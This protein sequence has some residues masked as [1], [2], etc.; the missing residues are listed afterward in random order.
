MTFRPPIVHTIPVLRSAT[1]N[2]V[3]NNSAL[4][5]PNP[6]VPFSQ[7]DWPVC[8]RAGVP[9]PDTVRVTGL[10]LLAPN[11]KVPFVNGNWPLP[12]RGAYVLRVTDTTNL[13]LTLLAPIIAP[14]PFFNTN[15]PLPARRSSSVTFEPISPLKTLLAPA[16]PFSSTDWPAPTRV[17]LSLHQE[18]TSSV[19]PLRAPNPSMPFR[20]NDWPT[21]Q[22][23]SSQ[24]L[25]EVW[26]NQLTRMLTSG[27]PFSQFDWP[28]PKR[29]VYPGLQNFDAVLNLNLHPGAV[30]RAF[31]VNLI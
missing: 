1:D 15:W 28:V 18:D 8:A 26:S 20:T 2:A 27:R 4:L 14:A 29:Q 11:P 25:R 10:A 13:L 31:I 30:A 23:V 6:A 9:Q 17:R 3:V 22:R 21:A 5:A 19:L 24:T 16:A 7:R 12:A